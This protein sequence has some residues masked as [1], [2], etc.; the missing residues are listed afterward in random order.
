MKNK[1]RQRSSPPDLPWSGLALHFLTPS[2]LQTLI[3]LGDSHCFNRWRHEHAQRWHAY[4]HSP[5]PP[6]PYSRLTALLWRWEIRC[7]SE[8]RIKVAGADPRL[9]GMPWR[10]KNR[11]R[12]RVWDLIWLLLH[13]PKTL[14]NTPTA[15]NTFNTDI[16]SEDIS[17][18]NFY[19]C[20]IDGLGDVYNETQE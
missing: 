1:P 12:G 7:T 5:P 18:F 11:A 10:K 16:F 20:L 2:L 13:T 3:Q 8:M 19:L 14:H 6:G 4:R 17:F 15:N 9:S